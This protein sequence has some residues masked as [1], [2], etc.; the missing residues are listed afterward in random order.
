MD[1]VYA[2][3]IA[4]LFQNSFRSDVVKQ[5]FK[6]TH[7]HKKRN[8][9]RL[10]KRY[11]GMQSLEEVI[12]LQ[13]LNIFNSSSICSNL[14]VELLEAWSIEKSPKDRKVPA[15]KRVYEAIIKKIA[16]RR[17]DVDIFS[18]YMKN[19]Y[20]TTA[21][22]S[23]TLGSLKAPAGFKTQ[24]GMWRKVTKSQVELLYRFPLSPQKLCTS[25]KHLVTKKHILN[26]YKNVSSMDLET[27]TR[28]AIS[29]SPPRY[30]YTTI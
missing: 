14:V 16:D 27:I 24:K 12:E 4:R 6:L 18:A 2:T 8:L 23:R 10:L 11:I 28:S 26:K 3:F 1:P 7:D 25:P 17:S 15:Y 19:T 20:H 9:I 21:W 29:A 30:V 5:N 22:R 13:G